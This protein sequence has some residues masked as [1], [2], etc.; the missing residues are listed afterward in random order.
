MRGALRFESTR[1]RKKFPH[2]S[3]E[4]EDSNSNNS[5]T[6]HH[7]N[8][9]E[10]ELSGM[11]SSS[12]AA[13]IGSPSAI[14]T[15]PTPPPRSRS[16]KNSIVISME[17][18]GSGSKTFVRGPASHHHHQNWMFKLAR[19]CIMPLVMVSSMKLLVLIIL[20]LQNSLFV[21]LRR[22]SQG[23][24][25]EK[26]SKYEVL[27][28]GEIIKLLVSA[29]MI[30]RALREAATSPSTTSTTAAAT[31]AAATTTVSMGGTSPPVTSNTA[32]S[33]VSTGVPFASS[34]DD[35]FLQQHQQQRPNH[36]TA[37]LLERLR[38]VMQH[39]WK[40]IGLALIYGAMNILSFV[41]LRNIG[42]GLF[43]II[44]QCKI[45][46]T[47]VFSAILLR[48]QYSGTQWRALV[49]LLL[50]VL[51]F[52]EPI[53]NSRSSSLLVSD[54]TAA[55]E[56]NVLLGVAAV[57]T[58]VT[59]SGFASIYFEKVIKTDPI[60]MTIWERNF[61]LAMVRR[62]FLVYSVHLRSAILV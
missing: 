57:A 2:V 26:Y 38:F 15:H 11:I 13:S 7:N 9:N 8:I 29:Y 1:E 20:S 28:V 17:T 25:K 14:P 18:S 54:I 3:P 44:S 50:G 32:A 5:G 6:F 51:L 61:Q 53:L 37:Q 59:L 21:V 35:V 24:L 48:R 58:E 34:E 47:A 62:S 30:H 49:A 10:T 42:A 41:A 23:V 40:M 39:A 16:H 19:R 52:S 22:Y 60:P 31:T 12:S 36:G 27:L 43:T 33:S 46:T 45:L 56:A 55:K 4:L